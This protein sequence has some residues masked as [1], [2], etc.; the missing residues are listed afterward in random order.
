MSSDFERTLRRLKPD[1]QRQQLKPRKESELAF[2]GVSAGQPRSLLYDTTVYVDTLQGRFPRPQHAML[3][4]VDAWHSTVAESELAS[5]CALLDPAHA[6][7]RGVINEIKEVIDRMPSHR[8]I[9]PDRETWRDAGILTGTIARLQGVAKADRR[10]ILN[11]ALIFAT[12]R[13]HGHAVLT[14]NIVDF[15]W[16]QQLD[17]SGRVL[18]YR[19]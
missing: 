12:A 1:K 19:V 4:A 17:P 2:L 6:G 10:R 13:K 5:I 11:D 14:R 16:L 3:R 9:A 8:T 15:D 7:T 18:F